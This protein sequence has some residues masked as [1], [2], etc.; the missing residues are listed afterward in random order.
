MF[1]ILD[2]DFLLMF[3]VLLLSLCVFFYRILM[4][5]F[6]YKYDFLISKFL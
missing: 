4:I 6:F 1:N 2:I 3:L 5:L